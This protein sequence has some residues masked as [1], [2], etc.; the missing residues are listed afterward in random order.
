ML[1]WLQMVAVIGNCEVVMADVMIDD[2]IAEECCLRSRGR[3]ETAKE[4]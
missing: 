4:R 3:W 2:S 1:P